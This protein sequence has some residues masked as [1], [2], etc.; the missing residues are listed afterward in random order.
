MSTEVK[1][2]IPGSWNDQGLQP[3]T[4]KPRTLATCRARFPDVFSVNTSEVIRQMIREEIEKYFRDDG[5]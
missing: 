3:E 4:Y 1:I 2:T 5:K